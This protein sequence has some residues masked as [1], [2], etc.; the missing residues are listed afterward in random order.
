LSQPETA[1]QHQPCTRKQPVPEV[2]RSR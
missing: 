2:Q 1:Q